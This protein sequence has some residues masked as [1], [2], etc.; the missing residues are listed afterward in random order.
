[1]G[2]LALEAQIRCIT[3]CRNPSLKVVQKSEE[4]AYVLKQLQSIE[5]VDAAA[6]RQLTQ[7]SRQLKG[8]ERELQDSRKRA[9]KSSGF[10]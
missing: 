8:E 9:L 5:E 4:L 2:C 3:K 7:R 6:E 1:M 10:E